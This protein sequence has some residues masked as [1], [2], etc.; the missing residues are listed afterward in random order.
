MLGCVGVGWWPL[1]HE[2][3]NPDK[4]AVN[5]RTWLFLDETAMV[6]G[7]PFVELKTTKTKKSRKRKGRDPEVLKRMLRRRQRVR[8][9]KKKAKKAKEV[10]EVREVKEQVLNDQ[11]ESQN[12][13][14]VESTTKE[15]ATEATELLSNDRLTLLSSVIHLFASLYPDLMKTEH[16]K[17]HKMSLKVNRS[18]LTNASEWRLGQ[19]RYAK[20]SSDS[21][22]LMVRVFRENAQ[23]EERKCTEIGKEIS[24]AAILFFFRNVLLAISKTMSSTQQKLLGMFPDSMECLPFNLLQNHMTSLC[25]ICQNVSPSRAKRSRVFLKSRNHQRGTRAKKR[26]KR[27]RRRRFARV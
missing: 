7:H 17:N 23:S 21:F 2:L 25:C 13:R 19:V 22:E 6:L 4:A 24:Q 12:D 26:K 18:F 16:T 5:I 14:E 9:E 10:K 20:S 3:R 8:R 1:E 27:T 15:A 11:A